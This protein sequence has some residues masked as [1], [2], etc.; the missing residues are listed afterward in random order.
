MQIQSLIGII[1]IEIINSIR[2]IVNWNE[3]KKAQRIKLN[4]KLA[5]R[6][7]FIKENKNWNWIICLARK[8]WINNLKFK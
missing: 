6:I 3:E 7:E 5:Q 8:K 1:L 2:L 4:Q